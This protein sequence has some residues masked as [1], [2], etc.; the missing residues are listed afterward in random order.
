MERRTE[1]VTVKLTPSE[2]GALGGFAQRLG[3]G[4]GPLL[5]ITGLHMLRN[6]AARPDGLPSDEF[7]R[8]MATAAIN[9]DTTE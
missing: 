8:V 1:V 3:V 9:L 4:V 7:A 6:P 2:R 5:R